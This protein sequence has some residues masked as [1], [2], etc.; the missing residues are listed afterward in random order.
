VPPITVPVWTIR[1][2]AVGR[3]GHLSISEVRRGLLDRHLAPGQPLLV[4]S[5]RRGVAVER[6]G[7]STL[8]VCL[9]CSWCLARIG[10]TLVPSLARPIW[11]AL[12][13]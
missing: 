8:L 10:A 6:G 11:R 7:E 9:V 1:P 4:G 5:K 3:S 12:R 2:A 13:G